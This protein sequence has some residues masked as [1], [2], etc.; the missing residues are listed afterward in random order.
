MNI[1][2]DARHI[3]YSTFAAYLSQESPF[4]RGTVLQYNTLPD[5]ATFPDPVLNHIQ[6]SDPVANARPDKKRCESLLLVTP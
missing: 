6:S 1:G 2:G 4:P 3:P 5:T